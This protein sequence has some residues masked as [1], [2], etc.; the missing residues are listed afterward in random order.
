[1]PIKSAYRLSTNYRAV[2]QNTPEDITDICIYRNMFYQFSASIVL[3][4]SLV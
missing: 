4:D 2:P 1:M 3:E